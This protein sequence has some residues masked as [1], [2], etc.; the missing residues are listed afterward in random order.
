MGD[1]LVYNANGHLLYTA[2]NHL[3]I[4]CPGCPTVYPTNMYIKYQWGAPYVEYDLTDVLSPKTWYVVGSPSSVRA[5]YTD[6][7]GWEVYDF[8]SGSTGWHGID[9]CYLPENDPPQAYDCY[10]SYEDPV[11]LPNRPGPGSTMYIYLKQT[12]L[13]PACP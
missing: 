12:K 8:F 2:N 3:S 9:M 6:A 7:D 11:I 13:T 10:L 5:R 1:H 4:E